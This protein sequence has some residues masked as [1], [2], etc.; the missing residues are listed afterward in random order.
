MRRRRYQL[1]ARGSQAPSAWLLRFAVIAT[2]AYLA[3]VLLGA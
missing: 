2:A 1:T 3:A